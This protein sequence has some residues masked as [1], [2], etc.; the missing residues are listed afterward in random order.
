MSWWYSSLLSIAAMTAFGCGG[1]NG[2]AGT[3]Q[4]TASG[5]VLALDGYAFPAQSGD[6]DF[7]D[8]WEVRFTKFIAVFDKVTLSE[9]PDTAPFDQSQTGKVVAE[10]D[11]PWAI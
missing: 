6:S 1:S 4:L 2:I 11:G 5:E 7:V 9:H 8:G 3:V 10:I